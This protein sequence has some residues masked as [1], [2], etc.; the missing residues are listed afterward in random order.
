MLAGLRRSLAR[1][2]RDE[3]PPRNGARSETTCGALLSSQFSLSGSHRSTDTDT[4]ATRPSCLTSLGRTRR[5]GLAPWARP[6]TTVTVLDHGVRRNSSLALDAPTV[7]PPRAYVSDQLR[8]RVVVSRQ[9]PTWCRTDRFAL[10]KRDTD[11]NGQRSQTNRELRDTRTHDHH[12]RLEKGSARP[13]QPRNIRDRSFR[14]SLP[15]RTLS[16]SLL[17]QDSSD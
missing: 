7:V 16:F 17:F 10:Y 15:W 8:L 14:C 4:R 11:H 13:E 1:F 3:T 9:L 6:A 12:L 2:H 5:I